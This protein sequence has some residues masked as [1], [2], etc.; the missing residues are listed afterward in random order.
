ME[1]LIE[2]ILEIILEGGLELGM[3]KKV[4]LPLRIFALVIFLLLYSIVVGGLI[5]LAITL[6][7]RGSF[8]LSIM[9]FV[10]GLVLAIG[11]IRVVIKKYQECK[12]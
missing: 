2:L 6:W 7:R 5:Y 3:N 11:V 4:C 10:V 12:R 9:F 1:I 8:I